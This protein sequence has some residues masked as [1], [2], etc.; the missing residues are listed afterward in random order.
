MTISKGHHCLPVALGLVLLC[1]SLLVAQTKECRFV[2]SSHAVQTTFGP[3][4]ELGP[5]PSPDGKWLAFEYIHPGL[6]VSPQI[7][8]M[9]RVRG[10]ESA[11]PVI[12]DQNNNSWPDWS[13]DSEWISFTSGQKAAQGN[14]LTYQVY[15]VR[16]SDGTVV[17]LTHF[18]DE[19]VLKDSTSWS[20]DGRIAFIYDDCIYTVNDAGGEP[21]KLINLK[22]TLSP[23][24]LWGAVWSPNG[25][26]LAF[27]GTPPGAA[28]ED[29]RLWIVDSDGQHMIQVTKGPMDDLPSWLNN[30]HILFERWTKTG[31]VRIC[32]V[33]LRTLQVK[34]L[35]RNHIDHTPAADAAGRLLF[36][37]RAELSK[38]NVHAWLP[39]THIWQVPIHLKPDR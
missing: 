6:D 4:A 21:K 1:Y 20:R 18:P 28:E 16:I 30:D 39:E 26:R 8:I 9:D 5:A 14:V 3:R 37:A 24:S 23:G 7:W 31:E 10:P 13:P 27:R 25:A 33:C 35:T 36:F 12:D 15:K 2:A 22:Q 17:Q 29:Q 32:V 19:T 34:Y 11:R 38:K